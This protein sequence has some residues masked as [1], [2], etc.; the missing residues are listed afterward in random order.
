MKPPWAIAY[1]L[2]G[3]AAGSYY[4]DWKW[5]INTRTATRKWAAGYLSK[6]NVL[7]FWGMENVVDG[8]YGMGLVINGNHRFIVT[9]EIRL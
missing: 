7:V 5:T 9:R 8:P 4:A 1:N 3:I 2:V 6:E